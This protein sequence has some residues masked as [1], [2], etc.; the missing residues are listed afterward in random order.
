VGRSRNENVT[1]SSEVDDPEAVMDVHQKE[2][3]PGLKVP[4]N[5]LGRG[6]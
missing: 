2:D 3:D 1:Y 4:M 5:V 6:M